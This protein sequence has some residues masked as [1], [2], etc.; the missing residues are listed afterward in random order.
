MNYFKE[1]STST[2][3]F[4]VDA[5]GER[6]LLVDSD[7]QHN[8]KQTKGFTVFVAS[9]CS[10]ESDSQGDVDMTHVLEEN[11]AIEFKVSGL[12]EEESEGDDMGR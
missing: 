11:A 4:W 8:I 12:F 2:L 1:F 5:L 6:F 7:K 3:S 10:E 9:T